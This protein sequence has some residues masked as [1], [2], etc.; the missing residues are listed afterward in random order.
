MTPTLALRE[1]PKG[2]TGAFQEALLCIRILSEVPNAPIHENAENILRA[3]AKYVGSSPIAGSGHQTAFASINTVVMR[4][5]FDNSELAR[6][7]LL[8]MVPVIRQHWATKLIGLRDELLVTTM[9]V[10]TI[11]TDATRRNPSGS[12]TV[13]I[14]GLVNTLQRE[15]VKRSEKDTLQVD[16]LAFDSKNQDTPEKFHLWPRLEGS[17]SEHNW[18]LIWVIA[19]LLELSE[20]LA[21]RLSPSA[22]G[23]TPTKKPRIASKID[24][25]FRDSTGSFGIKRVCALQLIPFLPKHYVSVESKVSLLE[26]LIPNIHDDNTT[27]S[28]W[29]MIA[30]ARYGSIQE[31][32]DIEY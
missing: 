25:V 3:L 20:E 22:K 30:I 32:I 31:V 13:A 16:E 6:N 11:L 2:P 9:F 14:D 10:V 19:R 26:R 17:R 24:D 1:K 12:L 18:T 8:D 15:Y 28:S 7:T 21:L 4:T 29:T 5:I 27:I 23:E